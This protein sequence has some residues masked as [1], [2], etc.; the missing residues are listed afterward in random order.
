MSPLFVRRLH[1]RPSLQELP[2]KA[3]QLLE[4]VGPSVTRLTRFTSPSIHSASPLSSSLLSSSLLSSSPLSS[5]LLSSSRSAKSQSAA[6]RSQTASHDRHAELR[7]KVRATLNPGLLEATACR[8]ITPINSGPSPRRQTESR[9]AVPVRR[10]PLPG[11]PVP[12]PPAPSASAA[13]PAERPTRQ[14][15]PTAPSTRDV[16]SPGRAASDH[17][18]SNFN[19]VRHQR[20]TSS[21]DNI[22]RSNDGPPSFAARWTSFIAEAK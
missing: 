10:L 13:A 11:V 7:Q 20:S 17:Q 12:A 8:Y 6:H 3:K 4:P 5:S 14:K 16:A 1:G 9:P 22:R 18:T 2:A 19:E 21:N 15:R